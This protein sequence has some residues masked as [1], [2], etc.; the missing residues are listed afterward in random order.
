MNLHRHTSPTAG[1]MMRRC[2]SYDTRSPLILIH[3]TLTDQG[4]AHGILQPHVLS[5]MTGFP[6]AISEQGNAQPQT[7][8]MSQDCLHHITTLHWPS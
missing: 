1:V 8:K 2:F 6:G 5:L 3:D 7:A 4:Y